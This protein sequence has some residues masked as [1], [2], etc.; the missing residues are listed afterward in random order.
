V[1]HSAGAFPSLSPTLSAGLVCG[2][3]SQAWCC[4]W[5]AVH[6][7]CQSRACGEAPG[8]NSCSALHL[9]VRRGYCERF[10]GR[11]LCQS[12]FQQGDQVTVRW[13]HG[14]L[15]AQR[16]RCERPAGLEGWRW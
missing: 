14:I 12:W 4:P 2:H 15:V 1:C 11:V 3:V 13:T 10:P 16:V 6:R 9:A 7:D 5:L 8:H